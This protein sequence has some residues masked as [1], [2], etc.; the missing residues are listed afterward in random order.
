MALSYHICML[1]SRSVSQA[2]AAG[3]KCGIN[4]LVPNRYSIVWPQNVNHQIIKVYAHEKESI[5]LKAHGHR[6][7]QET[8]GISCSDWLNADLEDAPP[9]RAL[10]NDSIL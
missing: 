8:E 2:H 6:L 5:S 10:R 7:D 9:K 1:L 3:G 4:V